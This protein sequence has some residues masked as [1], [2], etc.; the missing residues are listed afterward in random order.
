MSVLLRLWCAL[1]GHRWVADPR[2]RYG[3][4]A[5]SRAIEECTRCGEER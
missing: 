3:T 5:G 1:A 4:A 2:N